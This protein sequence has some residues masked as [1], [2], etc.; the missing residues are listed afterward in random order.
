MCDVFLCSESQYLFQFAVTTME[1][2]VSGFDTS[3]LVDSSTASRET[4][5]SGSFRACCCC[6]SLN[7]FELP[8]P[9]ESLRS[10][11]H[12]LIFTFSI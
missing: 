7:P 1:K 8:T 5:F 10:K 9:I 3:P 4:R 11:S 6:T 12:A 2:C